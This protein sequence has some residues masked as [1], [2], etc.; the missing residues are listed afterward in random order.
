[1]EKLQLQ[2]KSAVLKNQRVIRLSNRGKITMSKMI[3][4][5]K[6]SNN[7]LTII[8]ELIA[9]LLIFNKLKFIFAFWNYE[10]IEKKPKKPLY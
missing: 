10:K 9:I 7:P 4:T 1:M 2:Q 3:R 8:T 6:Y 5:Y